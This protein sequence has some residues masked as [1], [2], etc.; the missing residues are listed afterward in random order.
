MGTEPLY[1]HESGR[2]VPSEHTRGPWNPDHQHG[3]APAALVARALEGLAGAGFAVTRITLDL[4]RPVPMTPLIVT[5]EVTKRGKRSLGMAAHVDAGGVSVIHA[6]ASAVRLADLPVGEAAAGYGTLLSPGPEA[7]R[8]AEFGVTDADLPAFH[9]T[10]MDVRFVGGGFDVPGPAQAWFR[11]RRPVVDDE[12]PSGLQRVAGA[13]DFA[14]GVSWMVPLDRWVFV[15]ADLTV[16]VARPAAGEWV[17]LDALT[18][19]SDR[20]IG[21]AEAVL[22]D[23]A[24]RVGRSVQSLVLEARP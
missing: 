3:G 20:G 23:E 4:L 15:N 5:A 10:G 6:R 22:Y 21:M 1:T 2:F 7:G 12:E 9:R 16:H 18:V 14:N 17:A 8:H 11:L 24:G 13:A 19:V